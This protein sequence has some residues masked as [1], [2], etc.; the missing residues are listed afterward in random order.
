[1]TAKNTKENKAGRPEGSKNRNKVKLDLTTVKTGKA[2][3]GA[4]YQTRARTDEQ[5][6]F[7]NLITDAYEAWEAAGS[8]EK[9]SERPSFYLE[10]PND[11]EIVKA[12]Q[13]AFR[14]SA[15]YLEVG[16][17]FGNFQPGE[18]DDKIRIIYGAVKM[19]QYTSRAP[20]S[21]VAPDAQPQKD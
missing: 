6:Y 11:E 20:K 17:R 18:T 10:V 7:D 12:Y 2:E 5:K 1:M 3:M 13:A 16:I 15:K 8:P 4:V 19:K 21:K 14:N 9:S